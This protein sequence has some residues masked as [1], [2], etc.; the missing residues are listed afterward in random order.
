M[1]RQADVALINAKYRKQEEDLLEEHI[2]KQMEILNKKSANAQLRADADYEAKVEQLEKEY[3]AEI[4]NAKHTGKTVEQIKADYNRRRTEI[5]NQYADDTLQ[6]QIDLISSQ[7]QFEDM[8]KEERE[9]LQLE[10]TKLTKQLA[11]QRADAEKQATEEAVQADE[12]AA[13]KRKQNLQ[14]WAQRAGEAI[15]R[16]SDFMSA[17]IPGTPRRMFPPDTVP[18]AKSVNAASQWQTP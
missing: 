6:R 13:A 12:A 2:Q 1:Q 10:L 11:R 16:I 4:R 15:G 9:K 3:S 14:D 18:P 5:D 7:L 17:C 8:G